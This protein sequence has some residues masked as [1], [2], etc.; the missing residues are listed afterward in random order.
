MISDLMAE[1]PILKSPS[2]YK[3]CFH[4]STHAHTQCLGCCEV[5]VFLK[6]LPHLLSFPVFG[7]SSRF[8]QPAACVTSPAVNTAFENVSVSD[9][10]CWLMNEADGNGILAAPSE[11]HL[12]L[13]LTWLTFSV[14]PLLKQFSKKKLK[15]YIIFQTWNPLKI[16]NYKVHV[17]KSCF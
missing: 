2:L 16:R 15:K 9:E 13:V 1:R 5:H 14:D 10:T 4:Y 12:V 7:D 3:L 8:F 6:Q 17:A 11:T